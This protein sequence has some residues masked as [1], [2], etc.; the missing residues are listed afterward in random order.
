MIIFEQDLCL[1]VAFNQVEKD[2]VVPAASLYVLDE[3]DQVVSQTP[4]CNKESI[5]LPAK[6]LNQAAR[7][8]ITRQ[9]AQLSEEDLVVAKSY[10]RSQ[11]LQ[12]SVTTSV[13]D[14]SRQD[15]LTW[16]PSYKVCVEGKVQKCSWWPF[17]QEWFLNR[18][19]EIETNPV[20]L[21]SRFLPR[22][23]AD[24]N[25]AQA[26]INPSLSL[27]FCRPVCEGIV[28]VYERICCP[29]IVFT[30]KIIDQ[31][32]RCIKDK[33]NTIPE[34]PLPPIPEFEPVPPPIPFE[35]ANLF[36]NGAVNLLAQNGAADLNVLPTLSM[37]A[38]QEYVYQRP[39]LAQILQDCGEPVLKGAAALGE[40]GEF[41]YCYTAFPLFSTGVLPCR[42]EVAFRVKQDLGEGSIVIYDGVAAGDWHSPGDDICLSTYDSRAEACDP[43]TPVPGPDGAYVALARVGGTDSVHLDSPEQDGDYSV[44][45]A[46]SE[47]AGLAFPAENFVAA[48]GTDNNRNWGGRLHLRIDFSQAMASTNARYYRI[49]VARALGSGAADM[50]TISYLDTPVTWVYNE[51]EY[52]GGDFRVARRTF[53]LTKSDDLTKHLIPFDSVLENGEWRDNQYHGVVD[54]TGFAPGRYL[55]IIELFDETGDLKVVPHGTGI[56]ADDEQ[57]FT[58]ETWDDVDFTTTVDF[59][60]LTHVF[61]VDNR[62]MVTRIE[63]LRKDGVPSSE[64]CQYLSLNTGESD[65]L[66]NA[67]FR[68]YHPQNGAGGPDFIRSWS[69]IWK[70][71]LGAAQTSG[72]NYNQATFDSGSESVGVVSVAVTDNIPPAQTPDNSF[73]EMLNGHSRCTFSL[74]LFAKAKTW[75]G[76]TWV[77]N[78][79][80]RDVASFSLDLTSE[81]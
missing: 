28:E 68:A 54:T 71:G 39:Y 69:L 70:R 31:L 81:S 20:S 74:M 25:I 34:F 50:S 30:P 44:R 51:P 35:A 57:A 43:I 24:Q 15:W 38:A 19:L 67:G 49:G 12:A 10:S 6:E 78:N 53:E 46:D 14:L 41:S 27:Q 2:D 17:L 8:V 59:A 9:V 26:Q 80:L 36:E 33:I 47:S 18:N 48:I 77:D 52:V 66:F 72:P 60:A 11:L 23:A 63:D 56:P 4:L 7:V 45:L 64:E 37:A 79:S 16:L 42:R 32:C 65:A 73:S 13:L 75:N 62:P 61:W 22:L 21:A 58:F 3:N 1:E 55:V 76:S 5:E 40:N 29:R